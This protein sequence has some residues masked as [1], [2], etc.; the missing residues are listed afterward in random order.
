MKA[1]ACSTIRD[2]LRSSFTPFTAVLTSSGM[3]RTGGPF[4]SRPAWNAT[5][6]GTE[7]GEA[8][9]ERDDVSTAAKRGAQRV[10]AGER[11]GAF[12]LFET[13]VNPAPETTLNRRSAR[14]VRQ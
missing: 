14:L 11:L 7:R 13:L 4:Q 10:A 9:A 5:S 3:D 2:S 12:M 8:L 6:G 1:P